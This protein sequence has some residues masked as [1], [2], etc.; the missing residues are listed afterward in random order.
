MRRQGFDLR[1][2]FPLLALVAIAG[3]IALIVLD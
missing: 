1:L 2:L 3:R